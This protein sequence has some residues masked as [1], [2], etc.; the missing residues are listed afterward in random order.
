MIKDWLGLH[1]FDTLAWLPFDDIESWWCS[2]VLTGVGRQKG[3][4]S[5]LM[6]IYWEIWHERNARIFKNESTMPNGI[7]KKIKIEASLWVLA[8]AKNLGFILPGD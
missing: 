2:V 6:L 8:G 5:L 7:L 4:V 1:N 3:L